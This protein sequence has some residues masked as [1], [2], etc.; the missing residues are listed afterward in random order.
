[1][2]EMGVWVE[3]SKTL[4]QKKNE[5][6]EIWGKWVCDIWEKWASGWRSQI[7][8]RVARL[9][10]RVNQRVVRLCIWGEA[11]ALHVAVEGDR[12][13]ELAVPARARDQRAVRDL[14]RRQL[15]AEHRI[16]ELLGEAELTRVAE[17][18]QQTVAFEDG[19]GAV[20]RHLG[21]R[22]HHLRSAHSRR[23]RRAHSRRRSAHSRRRRR[24]RRLRR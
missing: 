15:G 8:R 19:L 24:N 23:R 6:S 3:K 10:K 5:N 1:M 2:G 21:R 11:P 22:R 12:E 18:A 16:E 7:P 9:G 4:L 20:T 14:R 13:L 17:S